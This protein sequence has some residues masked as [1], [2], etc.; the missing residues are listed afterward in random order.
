MV[1]G[2]YLLIINMSMDVP[3]APIKT[4]G[5]EISPLWLSLFLCIL[6]FLINFDYDPAT[7]LLGIYPKKMKTLIQKIH[8][9]QCS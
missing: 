5:I 6:F 2:T 1:I 3:N 7:S 4:K 9:A 8:A